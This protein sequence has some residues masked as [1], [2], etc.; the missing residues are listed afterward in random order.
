MNTVQ[1]VPTTQQGMLKMRAELD[2]MKKEDRPRIVD[3]IASARALG[4]LKENAEYHSAK[5]Q[6]GLLEAKI[7]KLEDQIS[8]AQV[9]D[10]SKMEND[11]KVIFGTT[12]HLENQEDSKQL[13]F[14]IVGEFEA[15]VS[16]GKLSV[17]SPMA[18]AVIGKYEGDI[19]T[20]NTPSGPVEYEILSV[21]YG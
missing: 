15:D 19:I 6:Q 4:D 20:V 10:V 13:N 5:E 1:R 2:R 17:G 7:S 9:I 14:T 18:R 21:L 12:V 3:A 8:R 11:G 16:A